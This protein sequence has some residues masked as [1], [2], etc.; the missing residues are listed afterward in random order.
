MM[1]RRAFCLLLAAVLLLSATVPAFAASSF[2]EY[3]AATNRIKN[4]DYNR[5]RQHTVEVIHVRFEIGGKSFH[6]ALRRG[7]NL[8]NETADGIIKGVMMEFNLHGNALAVHNARISMAEGAD[9]AFKTQFWVETIGRVLHAGKLIDAAK[10]PG[11]DLIT[12]KPIETYNSGTQFVVQ[13]VAEFFGPSAM[14]TAISGMAV[15]PVGGWLLEGLGSCAEPT[16]KEILKAMGNDAKKQ[17]AVES[18]VVLDMF[19]Q[20]CNEKLK[21]EADR[22]AADKKSSTG[23][24]LS[25]NDK[26]S[27]DVMFFGTPVNQKW[28]FRCDLKKEENTEKVGGIYT[29]VITVDISHD[30][31]KFD[32]QFLWTVADKLSVLSTIHKQYPWEQFY[33]A[34]KRSSILEKHLYAKKISFYIPDNIYEMQRGATIE[35]LPIDEYFS[36]KEDFWSLHPIWIVPQGVMP[37]VDEQGHYSFPNMQGQACTTVYLTGEMKDEMTPQLYAMSS[38]A[39]IWQSID[40][41]YF[42]YDWDMSAGSGGGGVLGENTSIFRDFAGNSIVMKLD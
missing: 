24:R 39:S 2:E 27:E 25:A 34:W 42:N 17:A 29:G 30:M 16:A 19:Y 14:G 36:S 7:Y 23:W 6:G 11:T 4:I 20:R 41:P 26:T 5:I 8:D 3:L 38:N 12:G 15:G 33:D 35:E 22:R 32:S 28:R 1:K 10:E 18:A 21:E 13:N 40:A 31:W 37:F 9:P